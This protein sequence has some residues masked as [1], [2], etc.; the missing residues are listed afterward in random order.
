MN[1]SRWST[2]LPAASGKKTVECVQP[3]THRRE[4][5]LIYHQVGND[6]DEKLCRKGSDRQPAEEQV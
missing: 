4:E 3:E 5:Q 1:N 6:S 2:W